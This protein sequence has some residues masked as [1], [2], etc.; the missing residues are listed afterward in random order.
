M[1]TNN[2]RSVAIALA[3]TLGLTAACS[4]TPTESDARLIAQHP[5]TLSPRMTTVAIQVGEDGRISQ[6]DMMKLQNFAE[7][8]VRK[9]A[10]AIAVTAKSPKS[11]KVLAAVTR[12]LKKQ[13]IR[14]DEMRAGTSNDM[15]DQGNNVELTYR[16]YLVRPSPCNKFL[17]HPAFNFFNRSDTNLGCSVRNNIARM[18]AKPNDIRTATDR[19][20]DDS[21]PAAQKAKDYL[22]D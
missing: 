13:G 8:Y 19:P 15:A 14:D 10:H 2:I 17:E 18:I 20:V 7:Q 1:S 11:P 9:G 3:L 22:G 21:R 4:T 12:A 6:S 16:Y 5:V